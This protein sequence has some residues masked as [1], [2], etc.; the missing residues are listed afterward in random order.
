[1]HRGRF[2]QSTL[3][4][5][6]LVGKARAFW[7]LPCQ[8]GPLVVQRADPL[9]N[10]GGIS[11]HV[12]T[13]SGG[14]GFNLDM[15]FQDARASKCTSCQVKQDL[16]NYWTPVLYFAHANGS[17][18]LVD[19]GGLLIYYLPRRNKADTGPV[20]AF[21]DGFRMLAGNPYKRSFDGSAMAKA[22]GINCIGGQQKP[23]KRHEFPTENCPDAMRMEIMFPSC[24]D[25][26][27][28]DSPNHHS[29]VAWPIG[30]ENGPCPSG[31]PVRI[32]T[33]FYEMWWSTDPWKD[34]WK[35]AKNTS[36]PFVL[37]TGDPTGYSLHGD[38]LNGWDSKILQKA[39][40]ECTS[41]SGVIEECKVFDLYDYKDPDN[42]CFQ[43]PAIKEA[44]TGTL[45]AL[46]G[47]NPIT[48][49][50]GDVTV[51][52]EQKLPPLNKD[53]VR[54]RI[55]VG[56]VAAEIRICQR[57]VHAAHW[58]PAVVGSAPE[59]SRHLLIHTPHPT[60]TWPSHLHAASPLAKHLQDRWQER[61]E[62]A[63][64]GFNF[65]DGGQGSPVQAWDPTRTKFDEPQADA[66]AE[67][68]SAVIYPDFV[69]IPSLSIDEF[70][71]FE[72]LLARLPEPSAVLPRVTSGNAAPQQTHI[73][74]CTHRTRDC[75][76]GDIGEPLYDAL[77]REIKR[78]KLGGE[79]KAGTDG[80]RIARVAHIGGHKWA[81]NALVYR[82]DGVGD[83]Y[84][85][86]RA[87][88]APKLLDYATSPSSLPWFSRWRGRLGL[89]ADEVKAVYASRPAAEAENKLD[90]PRQ[91]L[92]DGV[93]LVFKTFEGEERRVSGYEGESV[94]EI[95]RRHE[96]PSILATCGGHCECATCHVMIPPV[97]VAGGDAPLPEMTDEEDEQLEFAIGA[98]D[99][100]RLACQ[101]PVTKELGEWVKNGGRIQLP[102]Y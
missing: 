48:P 56:L 14:S 100:S 62:L 12:H 50:P 84:G 65:T 92:G 40:D 60:A 33:L 71:A 45:P 99:D 79:L 96:L 86:L 2:T 70:P 7:R 59:L 83:W 22:I 31:Y 4:V 23:T 64:L 76:C 15:T 26:K 74:V 75:R 78:R 102:R 36:Q 28:L 91:A 13:I 10:P 21:P 35:E 52:T 69:E 61:P 30:D 80:V 9:T 19:Q 51:C 18:T 85:L 82:S 72:K 49:G 17:F 81:G 94:M 32:E 38:F 6:L 93:E 25:G 66:A 68:Y 89:S 20:K 27:H 24:W 95:A 29:H 87:E 90:E 54:I 44:T 77:L 1:M 37:S 73:F 57:I 39:I 11:G 53:I 67:R 16:S 97:P 55:V 88:D 42:K 46:P 101:L 8:G 41:K 98:T 63:K 5:L 34:R 58:T 47:C 3:G 43:S